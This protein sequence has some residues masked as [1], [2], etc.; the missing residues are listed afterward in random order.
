KLLTAFFSERDQGGIG[1]IHGP[2]GVLGHQHGAAF[3]RRPRQVGNSNRPLS[4]NFHSAC[5]PEVPPARVSR[6]MAS[7][8]AGQV[9]I[10]GNRTRLSACAQVSWST[11]SASISAT[12]GPASVSVTLEPGGRRASR[13]MPGRYAALGCRSRE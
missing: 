5:W 12:S 10:N 4:T 7:V 1:Q 13:R 9:V 8:K 6:Y 3:N 2:V 11:S